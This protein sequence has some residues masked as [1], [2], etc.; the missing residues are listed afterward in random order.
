MLDYEQSLGL[1]DHLPEDDL[2]AQERVKEIKPELLNN[3][4]VMHQ[5]LNNLNEAERYYG[6]AI[7][8]C[9]ASVGEEKNF[10]LTVSY[11]LARLFEEKLEMEKA[12]AIYRKIV[13]DYPGYI[14]GKKKLTFAFF[15]MMTHSIFSSFKNWRDKTITWKNDRCNVAIQRSV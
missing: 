6:L 9:E 10:K 5:K 4:A 3:I 12:L 1:L 13:E 14:D 7:Q 8:E 11:N 2:V 15:R